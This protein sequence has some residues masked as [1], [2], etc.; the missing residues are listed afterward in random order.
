[1]NIQTRVQVYIDIT[2]TNYMC[3]C[4]LQLTNASWHCRVPRTSREAGQMATA[5]E[6]VAWVTCDCDNCSNSSVCVV[7]VS[8]IWWT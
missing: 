4:T 2:D 8:I 5:C 7:D 6:S 3:T 1:M